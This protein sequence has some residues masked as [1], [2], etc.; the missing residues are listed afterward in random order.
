MDGSMSYSV[1]YW[2]H[3]ERIVLDD[4]TPEQAR[5]YVF[6]KAACWVELSTVAEANRRNRA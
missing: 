5:T 2:E 6:E 4:L 1:G 3:G